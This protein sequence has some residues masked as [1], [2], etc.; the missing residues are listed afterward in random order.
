[1]R[2]GSDGLV[3]QPL[4]SRDIDQVDGDLKEGKVEKLLAQEVGRDSSYCQPY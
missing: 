3:F 4:F 2:Y 1:M